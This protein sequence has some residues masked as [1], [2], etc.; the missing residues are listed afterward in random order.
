MNSSSVA[1]VSGSRP[2]DQRGLNWLSRI[3]AWCYDHR[4]AVLLGWLA[5]VIVVIAVASTFGSRFEDN[6]GGVGQSQQAQ[7]ILAH[8][9]PAQ[10]GD[11]AQVVFHSSGRINAPAT[12]AR[13]DQALDGIRPLA[14]VTSVSPLVTAQDVRTAFATV[15]F[16]AITAKL[17]STDIQQVIDKA[18]SYEQPGLQVALGGP[19][20]S[21][22]VAPSPGPSEA[23]G[24][25]AAIIIMLLAFGSVVAMGLPLITALVGVGTGYGV[26]ALISHL[27]IDPSFGPEMMAMIGLGVGIDYALFIVTRYRQELGE[28]LTP[29]GA[30][31]RAM[32]TAGRAVLF[33]G[34]TVIISLC[35]L[36]IVGQEYLDGLAVGAIL[37]VLAVMAAALTLLPAM[38]GYAGRAIDRLHLPGLMRS[39][40]P[41]KTTPPETVGTKPEET[42][43]V[44]VAVEP[45]RAAPPARMRLGRPARPRAA[46]RP[47][48]LDA[49][50]IH[51]PGQRPHQPHHPSGIRPD[52]RRLRARIQRPPGRGS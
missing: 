52:L 20:I 47:A 31:S 50:G 34:I 10:A 42:R 27:L 46:G 12:T 8:K 26:V 1:E 14:S 43:G 6:F 5:G 36:F 19:P 38:L 39:N 40:T 45:H 17:P 28:G 51:R 49:P 33:A 22:Q 32:S 3:G 48:V 2:A 11:E 15:Q 13:V 24:I 44:L 7:N 35:G 29:R 23:I 21:A 4:R 18:Q 9:F 37:A 25:G 16:D 41:P 30:V